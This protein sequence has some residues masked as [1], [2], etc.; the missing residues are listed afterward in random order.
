MIKSSQH[1]FVQSSPCPTNL[2]SF[3]EENTHVAVRIKWSGTIRL[4]S[5]GLKPV[6]DDAGEANV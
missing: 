6:L 2:F 5:F 3:A 4:Y 1:G